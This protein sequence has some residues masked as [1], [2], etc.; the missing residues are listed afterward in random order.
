MEGTQTC[1]VCSYV[2]PGNATICENP[3]CR[4]ALHPET[5][6]FSSGETPTVIPKGGS[7]HVGHTL[8]L[9]VRGS[10]ESLTVDLDDDIEIVMG[11]FD[12]TTGTSPDID[13]A[14]HEAKEKGVSRRHAVLIYKDGL[15][16]I[17]DLESANATYLNGHR[18]VPHQPRI[19]RDSDNLTLGAL[20]LVVQFGE[21]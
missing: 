21:H 16:K 6:V 1:P 9:H 12:A 17:S 4:T 11:R 18:L 13:F 19:L 14:A 3:R 2:N 20:Q 15:L 7:R 10:D 5:D 8:F